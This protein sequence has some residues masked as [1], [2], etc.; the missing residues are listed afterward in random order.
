MLRLLSILFLT[1]SFHSEKDARTEATLPLS[2]KDLSN[3]V[4]YQDDLISGCKPEGKEGLASLREL[5]VKTLICVDGVAP[6]VALATEFE[7]NTV[8]LPWKY[9]APTDE[10]IL[11]VTTVF[12]RGRTVGNVYIHC[13]HGKHRSAAAAAVASIA[14]GEMTLEQAI[15]RMHISQTSQEY[16]GLWDAVEHTTRI[17]I[18]AIE[19]N[20]KEFQSIVKPE[21]MLD[22]MI[23]MDEALDTL[24]L[25]QE[26]KW[27]SALEE[28]SI[29]SAAEAGTIVE[30][31]RML[32][33]SEEVNSLPVDFET[34]LVNALHQANGL[35]DSLLQSLPPKKLDAHFEKV[36]QSCV[37]CHS[38]FRN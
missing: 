8:H 28:R 37:A 34:L 9:N 31:Y 35:E 24:E 22:L 5:G 26:N 10:Q 13:H 1:Y 7:I 18:E 4:F 20:K 30:S 38:V 6:N 19:K 27:D 2:F 21:G 25:L 3:V 33:L 17:P 14:L 15:Q 36:K 29:V 11:N 12:A 32:Q 23:T 16:T